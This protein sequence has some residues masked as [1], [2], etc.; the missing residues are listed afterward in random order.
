MTSAD[1][2]Q[3]AAVDVIEL[4]WDTLNWK[5]Q[6]LYFKVI[7]TIFSVVCT[8]CT[9]FSVVCTVGSCWR[10]RTCR[11]NYGTYNRIT[12]MKS[13]SFCVTTFSASLTLY[14]ALLPLSYVYSCYVTGP[15]KHT[16]LRAHD[17]AQSPDLWRQPRFANVICAWTW[18][19]NGISPAVLY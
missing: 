2:R 11:Q 18:R 19:L 15:K 17:F 14:T 10:Y 6:L 7:C 13:P 3:Q 4:V 16:D 12:S 9:I 5:E 8:V 1:C